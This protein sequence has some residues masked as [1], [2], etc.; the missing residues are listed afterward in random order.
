MLEASGVSHHLIWIF[1]CFVLSKQF[2]F[3]AHLVCLWL[4]QAKPLVLHFISTPAGCTVRNT[5]ICERAQGFVPRY[6]F[7][8]LI[9]DDWHGYTGHR[10]QEFMQTDSCGVKSFSTTAMAPAIVTAQYRIH[11]LRG[12]KKNHT[13]ELTRCF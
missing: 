1:F 12:E 2:F 6:P 8:A 11:K 4:I 10:G 5:R 3:D 13:P 9:C 7:E